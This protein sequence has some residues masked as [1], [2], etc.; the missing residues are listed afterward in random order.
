MQSLMDSFQGQQ[1]A[2]YSGQSQFEAQQSFNILFL[3][4]QNFRG[5]FSLYKF[6]QH[7]S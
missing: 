4:S 6:R 5:C 7:G 1:G 3:K 2:F